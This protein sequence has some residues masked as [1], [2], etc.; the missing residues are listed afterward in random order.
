MK[1]S[2]QR[3]WL[4][5]IL[6][7]TPSIVFLALWRSDVDLQL[8]GWIGAGLAA[9][10]F[11]AFRY[12][13]LQFNPIMLGIN[14]HLLIIT[15]IIMA[16]FYA[17]ARELSA[18]LVAHSYRGVL[19]T[20]FLAGC[21]LSFFSERG[22]VGIGGLSMTSRW[23]YSGVLLAVSAVAVIWALSFTGGDF[24]AVAA[25]MVAMFGLRRFLIARAL[26]TNQIVGIATVGVG[27]VLA[28]GPDAETV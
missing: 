9:A 12:F 6:E 28:T 20:V 27:S 1:E 15:P 21:G 22:F 18:A 4:T 10:L 24:L 2:L 14:T 23:R 3:E 13:R 8:S 17:G 19:V 25:P 5:D 11:I 16:S 26:D 7:A